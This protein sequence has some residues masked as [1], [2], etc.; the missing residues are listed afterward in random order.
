MEPLCDSNYLPDHCSIIDGTVLLLMEP[1][2]G[3]NYL[4]DH[5]SIIDGTAPRFKL[6]SGS[7]F[8]YWWNPSAVQIIFR[9]TVLLLMEPLRGSNYLPDHCSII[10]GTAPRFKLSSGSL[11]YY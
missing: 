9:I 5:C 7:L 2:R 11:F 4:P 3:S 8:Y 10:D 6:S 1:L